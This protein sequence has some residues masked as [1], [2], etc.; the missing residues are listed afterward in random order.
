MSSGVG[1]DLSIPE[2]TAPRNAERR[3]NGDL[4]MLT[5]HWWAALLAVAVVIPVVVTVPAHGDEESR[6][7]DATILSKTVTLK[8]EMTGAG[9]NV[10]ISTAM[11]VFEIEA[12][13]RKESQAD[14]GEVVASAENSDGT[15]SSELAVES[16]SKIEGTVSIDDA[17][18]IVL[19]TCTGSIQESKNSE[20]E[21]GGSESESKVEAVIEFEASTR[22]KPGESRELVKAGA[23]Q[24]TLGVEVSE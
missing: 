16:R 22:I 24:V 5:S 21:S 4:L 20:D 23:F 10:T 14:V 9:E 11:S 12:E 7:P 8:F 15:T 13:Q 19:V 18:G 6:A 17:T 3:T 2:L 1:R